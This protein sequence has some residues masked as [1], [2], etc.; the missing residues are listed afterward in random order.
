LPVADE[1]KAVDTYDL[2]A[3]VL[4]LLGLDHLQTT[5]LNNGRSERP[6]LVYGKVVKELQATYHNQSEG[7]FSL[8]GRA[9]PF[10]H[11]TSADTAPLVDG[12]APP[13]LPAR[14]QYRHGKKHRGRRGRGTG[15][16]PRDRHRAG[17]RRIRP[18]ERQS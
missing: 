2:H 17:G 10:Q 6:T 7:R 14:E 13:I 1:E 15:C 4:Q 3:T 8:M 16:L 5:F 18:R 11:Q 9:V 12:V